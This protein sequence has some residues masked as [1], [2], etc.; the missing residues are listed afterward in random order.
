MVLGSDSDPWHRAPTFGT[1]IPSSRRTTDMGLFSALGFGG[2]KLDTQL[3]DKQFAAGGELRGRV[4]FKAG[5]RQQEV[6]SIT[7][8]VRVTTYKMELGPNGPQRTSQ[9]DAVIKDRSIS[10]PFV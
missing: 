2:G 5:K 1:R 7:A 10:G 9:S 8:N 4:I 3:A 6:K